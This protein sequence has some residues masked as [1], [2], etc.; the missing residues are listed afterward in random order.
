MFVKGEIEKTWLSGKSTL[1]DGLIPQRKKDKH[2]AFF[3]GCSFAYVA[4]QTQCTGTV[5][6]IAPSPNGGRMSFSSARQLEFVIMPLHIFG[7]GSI[8]PTMLE[9][10]RTP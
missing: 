4:K 9:I 8:H 10:S 6:I 3:T 1:K 2:P 7:K 5:R